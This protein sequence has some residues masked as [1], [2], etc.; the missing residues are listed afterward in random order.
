MCGGDLDFWCCEVCVLGVNDF[1]LL[2][3]LGVWVMITRLVVVDS[4]ERF[5]VR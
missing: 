1:I 3:E 5:S 2:D 4:N